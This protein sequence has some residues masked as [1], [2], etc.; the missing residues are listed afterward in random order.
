MRHPII[1]SA[2]PNNLAMP[3]KDYIGTEQAEA[4]EIARKYHL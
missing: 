4:L 2:E 1:K 3:T